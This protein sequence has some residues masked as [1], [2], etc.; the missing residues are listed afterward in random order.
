MLS[1]EVRQFLCFLVHSTYVTSKNDL[2]LAY[3]HVRKVCPS[4]INKLP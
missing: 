4:L 2:T 1:L 3:H